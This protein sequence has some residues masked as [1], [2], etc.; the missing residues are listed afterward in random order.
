MRQK[1]D[2][3][4]G[5]KMGNRIGNTKSCG[6]CQ[7]FAGDAEE[8]LLKYYCDVLERDVRSRDHCCPYHKERQE[9][10]DDAA[11]I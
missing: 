11:C 8:V 7:W 2:Y 9:G 10:A 5:K 6:T 1:Y 4:E 3:L